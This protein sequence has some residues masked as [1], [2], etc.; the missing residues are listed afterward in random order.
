MTDFLHNNLIV[1]NLLATYDNVM[2]LKIFVDTD[3]ESLKN[4]YAN[5]SINHNNKLVTQSSYIDAG[6]DLYCPNDLSFFGIRHNNKNPL[7][8]I[9]FNICCSAQIITDLG[10]IFNTGYYL[11]PRSSIVKTKLR[12]S[13]STGIIDAGYRGHLIGIF[14]VVNIH[15][16]QSNEVP[17]LKIFKNDRYLQICAPNLVPIIVEIVNS[18]D[19]LGNQTIRG[20][21]GFGSTGR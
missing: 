8:K 14:D 1:N 16:N 4:I 12:L 17:D 3:D 19:E 10:K 15:P 20:S 13:N 5:A 6:F 21:G 7:N 11:Y 2:H 9:D 18:I